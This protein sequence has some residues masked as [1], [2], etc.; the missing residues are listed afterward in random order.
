MM[1]TRFFVVGAD[2]AK[3]FKANLLSDNDILPIAQLHCSI[4][5]E[6]LDGRKVVRVILPSYII[7]EMSFQTDLD[8]PLTPEG[9]VALN[10]AGKFAG[11][12]YAD[13]LTM[14]PEL[15]GQVQ[16]GTDEEGNPIMKNRL[17]R[18]RWLGE[19]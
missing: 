9:V 6:L 16:V 1:I 11:R 14:F 15:E 18:T 4:V 7:K 17:K 5:G 13:V 8:D 3:G 2:E 10:I 12:T 19:T